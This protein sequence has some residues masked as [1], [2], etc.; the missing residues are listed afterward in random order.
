MARWKHTTALGHSDRVRLLELLSE[1]GPFTQSQLMRL[2]GMEWGR[3]QW[4][5]YVLEREGLVK[6]VVINHRSYYVLR[7]ME[8]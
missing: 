3:L 8:R 5:L 4:H 2:T 7:G 1:K 6:R